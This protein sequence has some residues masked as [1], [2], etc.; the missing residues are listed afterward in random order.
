MKGSRTGRDLV[1]AVL[2]ALGVAA[3]LFVDTRAE[4]RA[5]EPTPAAHTAQWAGGVAAEPSPATPTSSPREASRGRGRLTA[6]DGL[7]TGAACSF[8]APF[9][10]VSGTCG[11]GLGTGGSGQV[12]CRPD[13]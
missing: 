8:E 5:Y 13:G 9:G 12:V 11:A 6:C 10:T 4:S 7:E 2:I 3:A 1:A